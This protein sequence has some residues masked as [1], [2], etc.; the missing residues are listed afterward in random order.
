[1]AKALLL[2]P[3]AFEA[4]L[5]AAARARALSPAQSAALE[6]F[7][8]TGLPHR[9]IEA[10]KWTDIRANL[11]DDLSSASAANDVIAPSIFGGLG[12]F[13]ITIMNGAAEWSGE[14]PAGVTISRTPQGGPLS[15]LASNHPLANLAFL[16]TDETIAINVAEG[17][18][19]EKPLLIR[20]IAG[21]G[22]IHQRVTVKVGAC[23]KVTI[24]E[25]FDGVGRYFSNSVT[26]FSIES[27]ASVERLVLQ[28]GSDDGVET[29]LC[30][31]AAETMSKFHQTALLLG[32]RIVRIESRIALGGE[33]AQ[34]DLRSASMLCGMRHADVT[35]QIDHRAKGCTTRQLHKSALKDKADGVFQGKFLV[36]RGAQKTDARMSVNALL[37]SDFAEARHKP[38][39]E[40]YADDVE[41]AH[42]S[43]VGAL[44]DA[45]LFYIKSRGL[46]DAA[47]RALLTEAFLGEAFDAMP[48]P[49]IERTFRTRIAR[50]LEAG[51]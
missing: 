49:A 46:D 48:H 28:N 36:A 6:A 3:T 1:M 34:A 24:I 11:R 29:A 45:A 25:S 12:A 20:R 37:L 42:G 27:G 30:A 2:N 10:W 51:K 31:V 32:A 33:D 15:E 39:L 18:S 5:V 26:E 16:N 9:R 17:A 40:I 4:G 35:S 44:D 43:T 50:W 19:V 47:G 38:E 21:G 7:S 8:K 14:A 41:C 22:A 13:E 23:S